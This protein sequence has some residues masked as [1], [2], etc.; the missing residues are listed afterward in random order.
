VEQVAFHGRGLHGGAR[1]SVQ[2]RRRPGPVA[3]VHRGR[4]ITLGALELVRFDHG[5]GVRAAELELEL[6]E[7]LFAAFAGIGVRSGIEITVRGG[8]IPL[9]DGGALELAHAL[10]ALDPPRGAA[11]LR[12]ARDG[13][14]AIGGSRYEFRKQDALELSVEVD[15][16]HAGLGIERARWS[17]SS[18]Q[19][20]R[21]IAPA[22]TFGF[23]RD[24]AQ[25]RHS[26]RAR[27]VD[28]ATVLV[29]A[30]DGSVLPPGAPARD[31]ELARHK[32]L[33]LLGDAF[34]HGGPPI[35]VIHADRPGHFA[36]HRALLEAL[37]R[38]LIVN[39]AR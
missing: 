13:E 29:F 9:L 8:E 19:F 32:L 6:V 3:F 36:N 5:V 20:L 25:L 15:F 1:C 2:L 4:E 38:G 26:G 33:D 14:L 22:R 17:G 7:H 16:S 21:E 10:V 27:W 28:P 12:I 39:G 30:E 23:V 35:G 18:D 11:R 34:V 24:A 37:A 31:G